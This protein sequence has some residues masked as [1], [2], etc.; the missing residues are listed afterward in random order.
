M[1]IFHPPPYPYAAY[2]NEIMSS[3]EGSI[4]D[5]NDIYKREY[6]KTF[7]VRVLDPRVGPETV[8]SCIGIFG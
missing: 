3:N 2:A 7:R 4:F 6:T 8:C 5:A 1:A